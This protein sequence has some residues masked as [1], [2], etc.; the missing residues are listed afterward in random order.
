VKQTIGYNFKKRNTVYG[1]MYYRAKTGSL[2]TAQ[3]TNK[4]IIA[5]K[6]ITVLRVRLRPILTKT[7]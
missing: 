1:A 6:L 2:K 5:T 3:V 4:N 7:L